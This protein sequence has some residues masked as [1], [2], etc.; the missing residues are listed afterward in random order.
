MKDRLPFPYFGLKKPD[1]VS[2]DMIVEEIKQE[3]VSIAGP[4]L[5][6]ERDSFMVICSKKIRVNWSFSKM[7]VAYG[8]REA[9]RERKRGANTSASSAKPA[10]GLAAKKAKKAEAIG[11]QTAKVPKGTAERPPRASVIKPAASGTKELKGKGIFPCGYSFHIARED[12]GSDAFM[13][14]LHATESS[15]PWRSRTGERVHIYL[16]Q[17]DSFRAEPDTVGAVFMLVQKSAR[18]PLRVVNFLDEDSDEEMLLVP[19]KVSP[20]KETGHLPE[21]MDEGTLSPER[22][23]GDREVDDD[24][25]EKAPLVG[26]TDAGAEGTPKDAPKDS[27]LLAAD[28]EDTARAPGAA[29]H[30]IEAKDRFSELGTPL[31]SRRLAFRGPDIDPYLRYAIQV[32]VTTM[33]K[34]LGELLGLESSEAGTSSQVAA[35]T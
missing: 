35:R 2:D 25:K 9:P 34:E 22:D 24:R 12:L 30:L 19:A 8:P 14:E 28:D 7:G 11:A 33:V 5:A 10:E 31:I 4:Y 6:K 13:R 26:I 18:A 32:D 20:E 17:F 16:D 3:V 1:E 27:A 15:V 21:I 29:S 23:G